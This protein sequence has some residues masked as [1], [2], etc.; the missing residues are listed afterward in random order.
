VLLTPCHN[1]DVYAPGSLTVLEP[2]IGRRAKLQAVATVQFV[3]LCAF[4][5]MQ[6]SV[7]HPDLLM[8][9]RKRRSRI[10]D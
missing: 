8:D 1:D 3:N 10:G 6:F 7:Q 9:E 2:A 5:E 4:N